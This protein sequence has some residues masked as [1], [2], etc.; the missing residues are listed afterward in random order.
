MSISFT[1]PVTGM[2][3]SSIRHDITAHDVANI[4][5]AGYGQSVPDQADISPEGVRLSSITRIPNAAGQPSTTD[6]AQESVEQIRNKETFAANAKVLKV[7]DRMI[8]ELLDL[9]A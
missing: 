8:G 5:T 2:Q 3:V 4:N 1:A 6:L 7:K 9:F